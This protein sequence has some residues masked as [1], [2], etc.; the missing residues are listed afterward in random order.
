MRLSIVLGAA[1]VAAAGADLRSLGFAHGALTTQVSAEPPIPTFT[2]DVAP[3]LFAHCTSCHR[4]GQT[5]PMSLLTYEA[6]RPYA[7]AIAGQ[8]TSRQM[9]PWGADRTIGSFSNDASLTASQIATLSTWADAGAPRGSDPMPLVPAYADGWKIGTPDLVVSMP[10][11]FPVP[12]TG[13]I[14]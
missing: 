10:R 2:R 4:P 5:A 8:T 11:P 7:R 3:I 9:P 13:I 1:V 14:E 12:A 6:A